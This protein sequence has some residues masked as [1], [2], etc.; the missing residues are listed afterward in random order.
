MRLR[1]VRVERILPTFFSYDSLVSSVENNIELTRS[2]TGSLAKLRLGKTS[3]ISKKT[4]SLKRDER[5]EVLSQFHE[6]FWGIL[7]L[8]RKK[9]EDQTFQRVTFDQK[10]P[11]T[12]TIQAQSRRKVDTYQVV[13]ERFCDFNQGRACQPMGSEVPVCPHVCS[14]NQCVRGVR[15]WSSRISLLFR[16]SVVSLKLQEYHSYRSF[17][18]CKKITRK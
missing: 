7:S 8:L 13:S 12:K 15:A 17:V 6:S 18:P 4:S 3:S 1:Y 14:G 16:V 10:S 2:N 11:L 5:L 9:E